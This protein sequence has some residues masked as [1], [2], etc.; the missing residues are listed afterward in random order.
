MLAD[1][2]EEIILRPE[3]TIS[4]NLKLITIY[5]DK[6]SQEFLAQIKNVTTDKLNQYAPGDVIQNRFILTQIN[7]DSLVL[8]RAHSLNLEV[9]TFIEKT[10]L[11][12][13]RSER[14]AF[15]REE[16]P[17][18]PEPGR[19]APRPVKRTAHPAPLDE[20]AFKEEAETPYVIV[21]RPIY[22]PQ[23]KE[24]E[25]A[26]I[27]GGAAIYKLGMEIADVLEL[28]RI[29]HDY[30]ADTFYPEI[31]FDK[32]EMINKEDHEGKDIK[33]K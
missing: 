4:A 26:F 22:I 18:I 23:K 24:V 7:E 9:D 11:A 5:Q 31:D 16:E 33:N 1:I 8:K 13:I 15:V 12:K 27:I 21:G 3:E 25:K 30:D 32:W 2:A 29:Y 10:Y 20:E 17:T 6:E 14:P 28:T 19:K